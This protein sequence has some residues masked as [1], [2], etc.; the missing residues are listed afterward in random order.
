MNTKRE[1]ERPVETERDKRASKVASKDASKH[2]RKS[3]VL[4]YAVVCS[5]SVQ[6][7]FVRVLVAI[8]TNGSCLAREV[9]PAN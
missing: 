4:F 8:S 6:G 9:A 5:H 1:R 7:R 2:A 3:S